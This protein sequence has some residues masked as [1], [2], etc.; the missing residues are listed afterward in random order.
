MMTDKK[1]FDFETFKQGAIKGMYAGKPM[2]GEQGIFAP[3]LKHFLESALAGELEAHLQ[4]E[5]ASG[6]SNRRNGKS[7]KVVKSL[8]GEFDLE[9]Q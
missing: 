7:S 4:N 2:S 5:K 8:S 3:L 6:L 9:S 1:E